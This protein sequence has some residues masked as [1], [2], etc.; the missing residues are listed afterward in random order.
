MQSTPTTPIKI[1]SF[2]FLATGIILILGLVNAFRSIDFSPQTYQIF[3]IHAFLASLCLFV[4]FGLYNHKKW[5]LYVGFAFGFYVIVNFFINLGSN[6]PIDVAL[7]GVPIITLIL[8]VLFILHRKRK[9]F[10]H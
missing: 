9:H 8:I 5:A 2:F 3:L 4:A 7:A 6:F 1:A 10:I